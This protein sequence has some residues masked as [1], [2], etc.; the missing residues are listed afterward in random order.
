MYVPL[1]VSDFFTILIFKLLGYHLFVPLKVEKTTE[2]EE[3]K[4]KEITKEE[5]EGNVYSQLKNPTEDI[6]NPLVH[7]SS[8]KSNEGNF[9]TYLSKNRESRKGELHFEIYN[10]KYS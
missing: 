1:L 8:R 9:F 7:T 3:K 6:Y 4:E 2:E 10:T 5:K